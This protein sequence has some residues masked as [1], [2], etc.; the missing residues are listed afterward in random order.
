[1]AN[2]YKER[3]RLIHLIVNISFSAFRIINA[4]H[5]GRT[6]WWP[7]IL[8]ALVKSERR[9]LSSSWY[10]TMRRVFGATYS[11]YRDERRIVLTGLPLY[12]P[13]TGCIPN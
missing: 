6:R 9:S 4:D 5:S 12:D 13:S 3:V 1:M 2:S 10:L 7:Y 11:G 8:F